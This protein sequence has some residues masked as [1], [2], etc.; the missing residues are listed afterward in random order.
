MTKLFINSTNPELAARMKPQVY[1]EILKRREALKEVLEEKLSKVDQIT[2]EIG[3]GHGHFLTAYGQSHCDELCVGIDV[4]KG[5]IYKAL[6]KADRANLDNVLFLDCDGLEFL[7]LLSS[8][9]GISKT[10]ILFPDPWP[11]KRHF[12]NRIVQAPF[13]QKLATLTIP[14]GRLHLRSDYEPY[15]DWSKEL[16]NESP[17]WQCLENYDWP[18][19]TTTVFQELTNNQHYSLVA[20][21]KPREE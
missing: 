2:L 11:K 17:R 16:L 21:L 6:R 4:N 1:E 5:R 8:K 18:E 14:T 12:K 10:W 7:S 20:E 9:V 3:C 13:L 19:I 15:L